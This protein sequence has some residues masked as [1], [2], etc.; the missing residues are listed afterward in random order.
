MEPIAI[1]GLAHR[2]P[3]GATTPAKLWEVLNSRRDLSRDPDKDRL[4]L[5]KFYNPNGEHH[6]SSN[7]TKSY[8]LD[9]DPRLFDTTFFNVSPLEAEAM[10]PQQRLLLETTYEAMESAGTPIERIRGSRCSVYVG[11]MTGDY[12][13]IQY[14]DTE[15][16]SHYTAS[17]TS[18]AILANRISYF[19]D[20][21]GAS[22]CLDTACSSSLVALHLAVQDLRSGGAE[23]AIVAGTNLI[24][25]PDMYISES[26]LRMLSPT[27]KCQMW[28]AMAD[29]YARG[30]GVATL[31]LKPLS[32][33]LRDNDPIQ[34]VIRNSGVNSDGRTPGITMPSALAQAKLAIE[35]YKGAGLDPSKAEDRCQYFEAFFSEDTDTGA[36]LDPLYVG[37]IKTVV[38]HLEGCAG[39][40]GVIKVVLAMNYDTIPPNQHLKSLNPK[41]Q[42]YSLVLKAP[43][44]ATPWPARRAGQPKRAS[45]NS[46]GFGGTNAHVILESYDTKKA[47]KAQPSQNSSVR[48]FSTPIVVSAHTQTSLLE[49]IRRLTTYLQDNQD[50]SLDDLAWTLWERRSQLNLRKSF[51]ATSRELLLESLE[52]A[53]AESAGTQLS[54]GTPA[55]DL[56]SPSEGFGV[57]GIFTGQGAQWPGM[58]KELL[59]H[60]PIFRTAIDECDKSLSTLPDPPSWSLKEELLKDAA[61]SRISE[62]E[63]AQPATTAVEIGLTRMLK[64]AG[65]KFNAVVGHSSGEIA[66]LSAAGILSLADS[67]RIAF[68]RGLYAKMAK[69]GSMMAVGISGEA[70][71]DFCRE[72]AFRGRICLA[73]KNSPSSVTLSGDVDAIRE[74]K[75]VF[76]GKKIFARVLMT[77]KAY[78]SP[79]MEA[80][81][82]A[83]LQAMHKC[84]IKPLR[85]G[86]CVWVSSVDGTADRYWD[87][88]LDDLSGPYWIANMVKPVLFS[89]AVTTTLTNGGPFDVAIEVG[90]H[91]ALKGP[92]KQTVR[93][94]LGRQI[95]YTGTMNRGEDCVVSIT[96]LQGFL[97]SNFGAA[98]LDFDGYQRCWQDQV[99]SPTV[100]HDLPTYSWDHD[101][102]IWRESRISRNYRLRSGGKT[103][104]SMLLGHRCPDD[105]DWEP[106]WRNFLSLKELPWLRGHSFQGEVLF[107]SA[108]YIAMMLEVAQFLSSEES[109]SLIEIKNL[110]LERPLKVDEGPRSIEMV[111]SAKVTYKDEKCIIA[112][113][114]CYVCSDAETG[115]MDRTCYGCISVSLGRPHDDALPARADPLAASVPPLDADRFYNSVRQTGLEYE[116]LFKSL[117]TMR[118]ADGIATATAS[119]FADEINYGGLYHP[120]LIDVALQPVFAAFNAP[121]SERLWTAYLPQSFERITV[122]PRHLL[123]P[124]ESGHI[125]VLIDAFSTVISATKISGD[126]S[127]YSTHDN[128]NQPFIQLEG[129][130]LAALGRPDASNDRI[131]F[132]YTKWEPDLLE[133]DEFEVDFNPPQNSAVEESERVALFFCRKLLNEASKVGVESLK[134]HEQLMF[135]QLSALKETVEKG[136]CRDWVTDTRKTIDAI[137]ERNQDQVD[138]EL[139]RRVG[140]E[141][142]SVFRNEKQMVHIL[143]AD[144]KLSHFYREGLG[145]RNAQRQIS[146]YLEAISHRY[147]NASILELGAGTGASTS[148]VLDTIGNHFGS[149][150]FTDVSL[151]FFPEAQKRF[152][153]HVHKMIFKKLDIGQPFE[154]QGFDTP[155]YDV[156]IAAN[157]LHVSEDIGAVLHRVRGL[158]KPGGF[159]VVTEPTSDHLRIQV[160]MGG[161]EGWWLARDNCRRFGPVAT[162]ETWDEKLRGARFSGVD[163]FSH[164]QKQDELHTFT[165]FVSQATDP[166][167]DAFR[168]PLDHIHMLPGYVPFTIVGGSTLATSKIARSVRN[169]LASFG[170]D[171]V[172]CPDIRNIKP[173]DIPAQSLVLC[174]ADLDVP[175]FKAGV[176]DP[177][178]SSFKTMIEK[179]RGV[180]FFTK[181]AATSNP[182]S[183]M[184][185]GLC[186]GLRAEQPALGGFLQVVD[187]DG[188][189]KLDVNSILQRVLQLTM[190]II[191]ST[192]SRDSLWSLETELCLRNSKLLIPRI[193]EYKDPNERANSDR[194]HIVKYVT[195]ESHV[196]QVS[197]DGAMVEAKASPKISEENPGLDTI[198]NSFSCLRPINLLPFQ[199]A[200]YLCAGIRQKDSEMVIVLS[201]M[202]SSVLQVPRDQ[203]LPAKIEPKA[204]AV[205]STV[206]AAQAWVRSV[207][208]GHTIWI[209]DLDSTK[210]DL[211][212]LLA[213]KRGIDIFATSTD[214]KCD[215]HM[216]PRAPTRMLKA[217]VPRKTAIVIFGDSIS[218]ADRSEILAKVSSF[219]LVL[220]SSSG[221]FWNCPITSPDKKLSELLQDAYRSTVCLVKLLDPGEVAKVVPIGEAMKG[222][223]DANASVIDWRQAR[224]IPIRADLQPVEPQQLFRADKTYFLVG[225][226]GDVGVSI[227]SWMIKY[228]VKYVVLASR[229]PRVSESWVDSM[230]NLGAKVMVMA[231]DVTDPSRVRQAVN[232]IAKTMP[233][234]AGV[235]NGS[236]VLSDQLFM[237]MDVESMQSVLR[238]KIDGSINLDHVFASQD[239]DFFIMLSSTG[240]VIGTPG[241]SNYHMANKFMSGLAADRRRRGLAGSVIDVGMISDT[242]YVTR[243]DPIVAKKLRSMCV[244]ALCEAEVHT[245]F[246]EGI[247]AGRPG[248]ASHSE[249]IAGLAISDNEAERPFWANEPRFGFYVRDKKESA[250]QS[251]GP[252]VIENLRAVLES[253]SDESIVFIKVREA[254]AH[255]LESLLQLPSG[256][257]KMDLPLVSLGLDSLLAMEVQT[258]FRNIVGTEISVLHILSGASAD[259]ICREASATFTKKSTTCVKGEPPKTVANPEPRTPQLN[260]L[261]TDG[262]RTLAISDSKTTPG[263]PNASSLTPMT[264]VSLESRAE[265]RDEYFSERKE[266][267]VVQRSARMSFAQARLWFLQGF[268]EDPTTYNETT[269]YELRGALDIDRLKNAFRQLTEQHEILRT[270]FYEDRASGRPMQAVTATSACPFKFMEDGTD[271]TSAQEYEDMKARKWDLEHG[272]CL[273]LTVIRHSPDRCTLILS[274]H[275][276]AIDGLTWIILLKD[277]ARAYEG[278]I[279]PTIPQYIDFSDKQRSIVNNGRCSKEIQFWKNELKG[280]PDALPLFPMSHIKTRKAKN[281]YP[282]TIVDTVFPKELVSRVKHTSSRLHVTPFHFY[283][284]VL[285]SMVSRLAKTADFCIGTVDTGRS[286]T[287]FSQTAGCFV[288]IVPVRVQVQERDTFDALCKMSSSKIL[289]SLSNSTIPLDALLDEL[290]V[291]RTA[292]HSPIFQVIINYRLGVMG[293]SSIGDAELKYVQSQS[294]GN[295]YDL[296]LNITDTPEGM[297]LIHLAAQESLYSK[298]AAQS[299]LDCYCRLLESACEAPQCEV[300]DLPMYQSPALSNI[301]GLSGNRLGGRGPRQT[302]GL[303]VTLSNQIDRIAEVHPDHV[304]IKY[305]SR[306]FTYEEMTQKVNNIVTVLRARKIP[307]GAKP[308]CCLL[309]EPSAD[310]VFA[311]LAVLK[312]GAIVVSLDPTNHRERLASMVRDCHPEAILHHGQTSGL[313]QWLLQSSAK[314][315]I[316]DISTSLEQSSVGQSFNSSS[317]QAPAALF[318]TSGTTGTPKGALLTHENYTNLI[319]ASSRRLKIRLGQEVILQQTGVTF[320]LCPFE[321]FTALSNA[322]TL[323]IASKDQRTDPSALINLAK[324]EGVTIMAGTPVEFKHIFQHAPEIM[325][326][327]EELRN[328]IVGGEI[329]SPQLASQFKQTIPPGVSV[330]NVYGPTETCIFAT[331]ECVNYGEHGLDLV[332]VGHSLENVSVYIVDEMMNLVADGC[333][334]EVCIGGAGVSKGYL[335]RPEMTSQS[336]VPDT[337]ATAQDMDRGWKTM[338]RTGDSGYLTLDG[339]LVVLGRIGDDNQIKIRGIRIELEDI[340]A[341]ILKIADGKLAEVVVTARGEDKTLLAFAVIASGVQIKNVHDYL[342]SLPARL[343]LPEYMRPSI[344]IELEQLPMTRN[345]KLDRASLDKIPIPVATHRGDQETLSSLERDLCLLWE[346]VLPNTILQSSCVHPH[347]DFFRLGGN[348]LLLVNLRKRIKNRWEISIPLLQLFEASTLRSM[349]A[350]I[351]GNKDSRNKGIDWEFWDE[352][353]RFEMNAAVDGVRSMSPHI[354]PRTNKTVVLVGAAK[355]LGLWLLKLLLD[356]TSVGQIHCVALTQEQALGLPESKKLIL[357]IGSLG[358]TSLGLSDETQ[359]AFRRD[360][361]IIIHAGAEGSCLNN[362]ES[363]RVQNVEST[364]FLANIALDRKVQFHYISSPRVILFSGED[365]YPERLISSHYPPASL[366]REGFTSTKW[367]SETYLDKCSAATGLPVSIHRTGYLMSEDADEMDAINMIHKYSALLR[368]VPSL[369][370]FTGFIDMCRLPTTAEAILHSLSEE[371]VGVYYGAIRI[372]HHTEDN[373]VPVHEFHTYMETR[374]GHP[375]RSLSMADW[376]TEAEGKGMDAALAAFLDAVVERGDEA[377]YP[378]L[379]RGPD[380]A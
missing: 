219:T 344:I 238:P 186:R 253:A 246:A 113:F 108:G 80:C 39:L 370:T 257:A 250:I 62:A 74:A 201:S 289:A 233:P 109:M 164:D 185:I 331:M 208:S 60:S 328:V 144:D 123:I 345:G 318:H 87:Q 143:F 362:Y 98:V 377:R 81:S 212:R 141:A 379:L 231:M 333:A 326:T 35:T 85:T 230:S 353:T 317:L 46:F 55:S 271:V 88:N 351:R 151:A 135:E 67:I 160:I 263:T 210:R 292:R 76:D 302:D 180:L 373:V 275:H 264:S 92:V 256:S 9:E 290:Q 26:K 86:K 125:E 380:S 228:G 224:S 226:T 1:I 120:A 24:F 239:L 376:V 196:I 29:G 368:A 243:Q 146:A 152:A 366:G 205:M 222:S 126:V 329:F 66:A 223:K 310:Y 34:A 213:N 58:G 273:G 287:E 176:D 350:M 338:Y 321:I 244:L 191:H 17:G 133:G 71:Q 128:F 348:S 323:V 356:D 54:L 313:S 3:G 61:K 374:F 216:P 49:N 136:P 335:D 247:L 305:G 291:S 11:V 214:P 139:L 327:C 181:N 51:H 107:P 138:F 270:S 200:Q 294:S 184:L 145:L 349:A 179:A 235:C 36:E 75:E 355:G 225:L 206:L 94:H 330:F 309:F 4:N 339:S 106:R 116:D 252:S 148:A 308:F 154:E 325:A 346:E 172:H 293:L 147:P 194:R 37:S 40:A 25:G 99:A 21:S 357:H 22:I 237:Q 41:V 262:S 48:S 220:T 140:D 232:E 112:E 15:D 337:F 260:I 204:I 285:A 170:N 211:L 161:L 284:A 314:D 166:S 277:L 375:F 189:T 336:F 63:I 276:I 187:I 91:P 378:R 199:P 371:N 10:D 192:G 288:N 203:M 131:L 50:V 18:R 282:T 73:A 358:E 315:V 207:P 100:I 82:E 156:I 114:S 229:N 324:Q 69:Y 242:G 248:F 104:G 64:S 12:E 217:L 28:D 354:I 93:P 163:L 117:N 72:E 266:Q 70:A 341:N 168:Q 303:T 183:S 175:I 89:D 102:P 202:N 306:I 19:F 14:R 162:I 105:S 118:R 155:S 279:L 352:Q 369:A 316:L 165:S 122:N 150:T 334:G 304:A 101:A 43:T 274:S 78:H 110:N 188:N 367:A 269:M 272:V 258:W 255:R 83:Y 59:R 30:E 149:Y 241:Q 322:G 359:Q 320:D 33:A 132:A 360:V 129:M 221:S 56:V 97:W 174:L 8:F 209:H 2:F 215:I 137:M 157:V 79:H 297:C 195:S 278:K 121:A 31:L 169:R 218:D 283:F 365:S 319:E 115:K 20:L 142:G 265:H 249:L 347:S 68:Y 38:G 301:G 280:I 153:A 90:P 95:P 261:V 45:V 134:P 251:V 173:S 7:V 130:G 236:M 177:V 23:T 171:V 32:Q 5:Q 44:K 332:P 53:L 16:L 295:P 240:S 307:R 127:V 342:Q 259:S 96:Q 281:Q 363:I 267:R 197:L 27:G 300:A 178:L 312:A 47:S 65:I 159:L 298:E 299:I 42:P 119:W 245:M 52:N 158:L 296:G 311:Y 198:E 286:G 372:I 254:F 340:A 227:C 77:D 111:T 193:R 84:D 234:I 103:D 343:P 190:T 268:L 167:I 57:L 361:D 364:K 13:T 182:Y 124:S 6:G